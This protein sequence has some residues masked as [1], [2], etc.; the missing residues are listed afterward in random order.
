MGTV[1]LLNPSNQIGASNAR[2]PAVYVRGSCTYKNQPTNPPC[3]WDADNVF[4]TG[5]GVNLGGTTIPP[6][7]IDIDPVQAGTQPPTLSSTQMDFW[8]RYSSPGP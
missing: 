6:D 3:G 7:L 4:A 5:P 8:Y 2:V 1:T